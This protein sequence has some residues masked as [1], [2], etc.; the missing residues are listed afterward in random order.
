MEYKFAFD[1]GRTVLVHHG[2]KGMKWGVWNSDTRARYAGGNGSSGSVLD[3]L[4]P[5]DTGG[6]GGGGID[7]DGFLWDSQNAIEIA[8]HPEMWKLLSN[9]EDPDTAMGNIN[10][11]Y[12]AGYMELFVSE[13]A[14]KQFNTMEDL[15]SLQTYK[16][17]FNCAT[18]TVMYD[19]RR[20]GLDVDANMTMNLAYVYDEHIGD[21]YKG[22]KNT[23]CKTIE[24]CLSD[25]DKMPDGARGGFSG[26]TV[27]GGG[28]AIS[29]EKENGEIVFRDCQSNKK[30][31]AS[32]IET[33]FAVNHESDK[34]KYSVN[35]VSYVRLDDKVPNLAKMYSDGL[36]SQGGTS[37]KKD[38]TEDRVRDVEGYDKVTRE[39]YKRA[40]GKDVETDPGYSD[41]E[42][43]IEEQM[44][45]ARNAR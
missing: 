38:R 34:N 9:P 43:Y 37:G 30:Y 1:D 13:F 40:T 8:N 18:C 39:M 29:W 22:A 44:E 25:L 27:N 20:R 14:G 32:T 12:T 2:V 23:Q 6:G 36:A 21:Y 45:K 5:S 10:P 35:S 26:I 7:L 4:K 16:S 41:Y 15:D 19:L 31:T 24:K 17:L 3:S 33:L 28:H 42:K 11:Y